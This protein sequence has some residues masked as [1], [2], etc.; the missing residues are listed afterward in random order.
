MSP[1]RPT[2]AL[3]LLRPSARTTPIEPGDRVSSP[4]APPLPREIQLEVTGA[5]NLRCRMCLVAYRPALPRT[6]GS[7]RIETFRRIVD[8]LPELT[9]VTLQGLGEPLLAPDL[10]AMVE[11]AGSRGMRVGFNTNATLLSREVAERLVDARL[12]WLCVSLDG[13]TA[14]TY[15]SIRDGSSF[16]RVARNVRAFVEVQRARRSA[17]PDLSIVFVAMRRNVAELPDVVR[18]AADWGVPKVRVQN[19]SHSFDDTDPSG[20]YALIRGFTASEALWGGPDG[21]APT[22]TLAQARAAF[23]E[24]RSAAEELGVALRLPSL[25]ERPAE[26][27]AAGTPGCDWPW[28]SA[29]VRH[30]GKAQPC[31][32]VMG[33]DRAILG[34]T[35][36]RPF[37]E[38][39]RGARYAAFRE[40]LLSGEPPEVCRGCSMYRGVF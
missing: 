3:P 4:P 13:A 16:D 26:R 15:E 25:D 31:C 33:E 40:A 17:L 39:W 2:V 21:G 18:L 8:A 14:A 12:A 10:L 29:Y 24:A 37:D 34:D 19:L 36:E 11:H 23:R 22:D 7:M 30:D 5:C 28:R 38:V 9:T 35:G 32:M 27:R 6:G 1:A 20:E